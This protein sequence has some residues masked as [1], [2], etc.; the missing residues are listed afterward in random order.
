MAGIFETLIA[1]VP[2]R[3]DVVFEIWHKDV[4]V[5]EVYSAADGL[6]KVELYPPTDNKIWN[7][8]LDDFV[9]VLLQGKEELME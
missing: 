3:E 5:A 8:D 1:S 7:F 9:N 6:L 4:Q 2:D